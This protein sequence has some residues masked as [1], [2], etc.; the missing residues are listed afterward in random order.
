M[1]FKG[2]KINVNMLR[3]PLGPIILVEQS[4]CDSTKRTLAGSHNTKMLDRQKAE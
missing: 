4:I 1:K 2:F 3:I